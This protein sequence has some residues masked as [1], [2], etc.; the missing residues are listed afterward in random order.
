MFR[1][2]DW[3]APQTPPV[4]LPPVP[5]VYVSEPVTWEYKQV[6][7]KRVLNEVEL[8]ELGREGWELIGILDRESQVIFFF[9]RHTQ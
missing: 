7:S 5:Y 4:P 1:K 3:E 2:P 8:N 6:V 9:K